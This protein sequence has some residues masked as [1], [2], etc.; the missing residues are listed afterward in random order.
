MLHGAI[1][2]VAGACA[3]VLVVAPPSG[4]DFRLPR[5]LPLPV[6]EIADPLAFGGPLVGLLTGANAA[7]FPLLVVAGGDMPSLEPAVLRLMLRRM[8]APA[9]SG[10]YWAAQGVVLEANHEGQRLP[11]VLDR[12][13]AISA[14][15]DLVA[16]GERSLRALVEA[17]DIAVIPEAE[18]RELDPDG[19]TL[20]D[21]DQPS[22][23]LALGV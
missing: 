17:L 8:V 10:L 5:G 11:L 9:G 1:R 21:I 2:A 4:L 15:S 18:W 22:D 20:M 19:R 16:A 14:A 23:L 6:R 7:T 3:E 13:A 12:G